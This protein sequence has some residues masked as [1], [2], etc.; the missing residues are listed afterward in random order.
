[1]RIITCICILLST[2]LDV[3]SLHSGQGSVGN[4]PFG[5][6]SAYKVSS[7]GE[8]AIKT[9]HDG[10]TAVVRI[11]TVTID[12]SNKA[13]P[14]SR[15]LSEVFADVRKI[16]VVKDIEISV[17]SHE[18]FVPYSVYASLIE[19][20]KAAVAFE[21]GEFVLTIRGGDG[22]WSYFV[23]IYFNEERVYRTRVYDSLF[24]TEPGEE[25]NYRIRQVAPSRRR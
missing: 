20:N 25:T 2:L 7:S 22:Y 21:D 5:S 15:Q 8:I 23:R 6:S 16:T 12:R 11:A 24:P 3:S 13:F 18:S 9:E 17:D 14:S 10:R 19:P 4:A 1:M